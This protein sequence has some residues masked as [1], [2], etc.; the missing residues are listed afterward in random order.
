[1][2]IMLPPGPHQEDR[3]SGPHLLNNPWYP[4][5]SSGNSDIASREPAEVGGADPPDKRCGGFTGKLHLT[6]ASTARRPV[7]PPSPKRVSGS[8]PGWIF[9]PFNREI[10]NEP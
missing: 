6:L 2:D 8:L 3:P 4:G 1:M 9:I 5:H 7:P 10:G